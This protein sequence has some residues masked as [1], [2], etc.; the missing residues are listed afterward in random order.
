[1]NEV[2]SLMR[3]STNFQQM[4]E[5]VLEL[6]APGLVRNGYGFQIVFHAVFIHIAFIKK[7][8]PNF[9]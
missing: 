5:I 6:S 8:D 1:M 2:E 4:I 9:K 7:F 3:K